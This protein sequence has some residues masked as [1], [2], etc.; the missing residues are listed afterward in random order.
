MA[1]GAHLTAIQLILRSQFLNISG[2]E[3]TSLVLRKG[4]T[5]ISESIQILHV[6]ENH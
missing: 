5:T 1:V 4:N 2:L 6:D 3:N